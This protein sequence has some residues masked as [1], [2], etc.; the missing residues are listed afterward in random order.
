M[1]HKARVNAYNLLS[2]SP[3]GMP[4]SARMIE[5]H[6]NKYWDEIIANQKQ[7][8]AAATLVISLLKPG[9]D[10]CSHVLRHLQHKVAY[11]RA[12]MIKG[13]KQRDLKAYYVDYKSLSQ[14]QLAILGL[15][16]LA[17]IKLDTAHSNPDNI[18]QVG[19][20]VNLVKRDINIELS[21]GVRARLEQLNQYICTRSPKDTSV[22]QQLFT[23]LKT[24]AC[25][26]IAKRLG[27]KKRLDNTLIVIKPVRKT[28]FSMA[29]EHY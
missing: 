4:Q 27:F 16:N 6:N 21:G 29:F 13:V 14:W 8:L 5:S 3:E 1:S 15:L 12:R 25:K 20:F 22:Q 10:H 17:K 18:M 19:A 23:N 28:V 9:T 11:Y 7:N 24:R 26:G 2:S